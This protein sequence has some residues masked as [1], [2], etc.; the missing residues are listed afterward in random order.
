MMPS[1]RNGIR[2]TRE[3]GPTEAGSVATLALH[4]VQKVPRRR[5]AA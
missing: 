2:P 5:A 1:V 3:K 4:T